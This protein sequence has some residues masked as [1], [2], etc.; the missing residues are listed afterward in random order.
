MYGGLRGN[1][2]SSI[3]PLLIEESRQLVVIRTAVFTLYI[4]SVLTSAR[5]Y[6]YDNRSVAEIEHS[7]IS[8]FK[9]WFKYKLNLIFIFKSSL[10]CYKIV[11]LSWT[12]A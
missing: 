11:S 2:A 5:L 1:K 7:R 6:V 8:L 4:S 3:V 9:K 12:L 10:T